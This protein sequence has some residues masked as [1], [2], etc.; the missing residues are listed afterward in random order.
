MKRIFFAIVL[1]LISFS[2]ANATVAYPNPIKVTQPDGSVLTIRIHGDEY[3]NWIT[4]GNSLVAKGADGY[5]RYA[6]FAS[7]GVSKV[8]GSIVRATPSGDGSNV[9]PPKAAF[10]EAAQKRQ[11][12]EKQQKAASVEGTKHFLVLLIQFSDLQF[13]SGDTQANTAFTNMLNQTGYYDNGATGSV[14]DYYSDNSHSK[15]APV[16]DVVGP[17]TVTGNMASYSE[18][19][20]QTE[21][22]APRL[23]V[24]ACNL[25]NDIIDFSQYD[26]NGDNVVDNV[27]YYFAGYNAAEGATGTIW[28]HS[29]SVRYK[30][31][32]LDGVYLGQYSCS[33]ELKGTSGGQ[34]AGIGTFCH[35]FGHSIGLTDFY[36]TDYDENGQGLA[37]S[38]LSLMSSGNYNNGGKTPPYLTYE[39]RHMLGWDNGLTKL[40]EGSN[41]LNPISGN[42]AY[43]CPTGHDGEYYLFESRPAKGWDSYTGTDG[44]AIYHVDKSDNLLPDG[45]TAASKW[46][47]G[48]GINIFADHQCM[49]LV[50]TVSPESAVRYSTELVFPGIHN[51]TELNAAT[52][53]S[54]LAWNGTPTGYSLS[55]ITFDSN[56]GNSTLQVAASKQVSGS[57]ISLDGAP[58][59]GAIVRLT[60]VETQITSVPSH[61]GELQLSHPVQ[62]TGF[63]EVKVTTGANGTFVIPLSASGDYSLS[64][65]KDGYVPYSTTVSVENS[66]NLN[67]YLP[68]IQEEAQTVLKK[69]STPTNYRLGNTG[70]SG[71]DFYAGASFSAEELNNYVGS[72]ISN[73]SFLAANGGYNQ[74]LEIG[75]KVFFD[76]EEVVSRAAATQVFNT[77]CTVDISDAK[78]TIPEGKSVTFVYY[79]LQMPEDSPLALADV[80]TETSHVPN[81]CLY[82]IWSR[83]GKFNIN[84]MTD[85]S[86][87]NI[88]ISAGISDGKKIINLA[89]F[90]LIHVKSSGYAA[91][92]DFELKLDESES[93]KPSAVTWYVNGEN[94]MKKTITLSA[95]TYVIKA[96]LTYPT[97]RKECVETQI[98]VR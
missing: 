79:L 38:T 53:P 52:T 34:M 84:Q 20:G 17:I 91:G 80:N 98:L 87:G 81:G 69:Y 19:D 28:P 27:F 51:V 96:D 93:N 5:Y 47:S 24:E 62:K 94:M 70:L 76:N 68:T 25:A 12:A 36:D 65:R 42:K 46:E 89:G 6:T 3:L 18:D 40:G 95:G 66:V 97:G 82:G 8:Q 67:I 9:K 33:S 39:E 11:M 57:V 55:G 7:S 86:T 44:L 2:V 59:S 49:D 74:A 92:D 37:L 64:V 21:N 30:G 15:F 48:F 50:E 45:T 72:D 54:F 85:F 71:N 75:V 14:K 31:I 29:S 78:L 88:I 32:L 4:C 83:G 56:T 10:A 16:F 73:I 63:Q 1:I 35:E 26:H 23:L 43:Y 22:G 41:T 90:N 61:I 13:S 58:L 77:I 60:A